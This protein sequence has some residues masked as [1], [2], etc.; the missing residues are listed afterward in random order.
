[1]EKWDGGYRTLLH[2]AYYWNQQLTR[3]DQP[4]LLD[5]LN[6]KYYLVGRG[7]RVPPGIEDYHLAYG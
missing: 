7:A 6:V 3:V 5:L 2:R 4:R 1:L